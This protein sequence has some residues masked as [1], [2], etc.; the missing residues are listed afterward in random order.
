MAEAAERSDATRKARH[1]SET[2]KT[3][4]YGQRCWR[5]READ[6]A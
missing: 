1:G 3:N 6:S 4:A 2:K 5:A